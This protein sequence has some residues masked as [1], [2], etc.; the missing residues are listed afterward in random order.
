MRSPQTGGTIATFAEMQ[1]ISYDRGCGFSISHTARFPYG[2]FSFH[3]TAVTDVLPSNKI[4][5]QTADLFPALKSSLSG[6]FGWEKYKCP[7]S[8]CTISEVTSDAAIA[9]REPR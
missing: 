1:S 9:D 4:N 6:T 7:P 5:L 3:E 2:D 8:E